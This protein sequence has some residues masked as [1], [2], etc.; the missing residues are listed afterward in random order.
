MD[1]RRHAVATLLREGK[2]QGQ[3]ATELGVSRITIVKDVAALRAEWQ[4]LRERNRD[5]WMEMELAK[6][7]AAEAVAWEHVRSS[8]KSKLFGLDRVL[9]IIDRRAKLLGLDAPLKVDIA[10]TVR[11]KAIEVARENDLDVDEVMAEMEAILAG[12][13][14]AITH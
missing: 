6:L 10:R 7:D 2:T 5:A 3:I 11:E 9:A 13:E 4:T 1:D 12:R 8:P 14:D